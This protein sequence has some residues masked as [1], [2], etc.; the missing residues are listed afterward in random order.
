V[1]EDLRK[2]EGGSGKERKRER[3]GGGKREIQ[4]YYTHIQ[5][6]DYLHLIYHLYDSEGSDSEAEEEEKQRRARLAAL[7]AKLKLVKQIVT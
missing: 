2:V 7:Q 1:C 3:G 6:S 5:E 4:R